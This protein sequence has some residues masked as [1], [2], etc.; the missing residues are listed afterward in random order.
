MRPPTL[1]LEFAPGARRPLGAGEAVL[2]LSALL[3]CAVLLRLGLQWSD[4]GEQ[5]RAIEAL[6][7]KAA[8]TPRTRARVDPG[9]AARSRVAL[10][11]AH[12]L[13]TPWGDLLDTLESARTESVALLSMEP[14]VSKRSIRLTA[15]ARDTAEMLVYLATLQ[16]DPRLNAVVLVSH[17]VQL[18]S[19]GTPVRFQIQAGWG[20]LP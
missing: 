12:H 17:Q 5:L 6:E 19:P 11:V 2:A 18:Q 9:E 14:S 4:R 8:P 13:L 16:R 7:A 10:Q 3:L 15:E 20:A 1:R